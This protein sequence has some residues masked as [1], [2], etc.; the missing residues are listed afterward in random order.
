MPSPHSRRS[1]AAALAFGLCV[2]W[3]TGVL[4]LARAFKAI[5]GTSVPGRIAG[6]DREMA[7]LGPFK[8][9]NWLDAYV[10]PIAAAD[11][12]MRIHVFADRVFVG[13]DNVT[14]HAPSRLVRR[15]FGAAV[16]RT[17]Q[18]AFWVLRRHPFAI[19]GLHLP[20]NGAI[21]LLLARL[22]RATPLYFSIGGAEELIEGGL[23]SEHTLFERIKTPSLFLQSRL[24]SIANEFDYALTM[25]SCTRIRL[26][27]LGL[28]TP[29]WD[30]SVAIDCARFRPLSAR[31]ADIH[32]VCVARLAKIKRIDLLLRAIGLLTASDRPRLRV[33]LIG[34]GGERS[35]LESLARTLSLS[36]CVQFVGWNDDVE[37]WLRR[38]RLFALSS[39]SEGLPISMLEALACGV[40]V[41]AP[42]V[43]DIPDVLGNSSCGAMFSVGNVEELATALAGILDADSN[44]YTTM[45]VAAQQAAQRYSIP[46]RAQQWTHVLDAIGVKQ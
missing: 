22:T 41:V 37:H 4:F 42:N 6:T 21:A 11:P 32:V 16:G 46:S 43:G 23:H 5:L 17:L 39:K 8:S 35:A 26:R 38:A 13:A 15:L 14:V 25:G 1:I 10:S 12:Q 20:W 34:D 9:Q 24:V 36:D 28:V 27:E 3:T 45:S 2:A 44:T 19:L 30:V 40:P 7:V 18:S 29:A 33:V 31:N